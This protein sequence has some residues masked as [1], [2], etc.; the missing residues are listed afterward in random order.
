MDCS[1]ARTLVRRYVSGARGREATLGSAPRSS[2]AWDGSPVLLR[3]A[4]LAPPRWAGAVGSG[5]RGTGDGVGAT[6]F[7]SEL[8][9]LRCLTVASPAGGA[10]FG[11]PR[12]W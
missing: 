1:L 4:R 6:G 2:G 11:S 5:R 10:E 8:C 12:R 9:K 7:R 3:A